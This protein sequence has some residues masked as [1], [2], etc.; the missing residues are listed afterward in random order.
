[1]CQPILRG[2]LC[3]LL[4]VLSGC[5]VVPASRTFYEPNPA[6]GRAIARRSCGYQKFHDALE[7]QV[8]GALLIV[9]PGSDEEPKTPGATLVVSMEVQ[10]NHGE[11]ELHAEFI[12]LRQGVGGPAS[13]G[14]VI[15]QIV[16]GPVPGQSHQSR[17]VLLEFAIDPAGD[18]NIEIDV[19]GEAVAIRGHL[20]QVAPFRFTRVT[21]RDVLMSSF[22]C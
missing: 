21:R 16:G 5:V 20:V 2:S 7:R 11:A 4:M 6:D 22:Y 18:P 13:H 3:A 15:E 8:D 12:Q 10:S 14:R 17:T 1:V 9:S 19:G